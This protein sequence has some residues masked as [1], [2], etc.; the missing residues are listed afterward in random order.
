M[1]SA[2]VEIEEVNY[3][4][5]A[6]TEE[7]VRSIVLAAGS[8]AAVL[9]LRHATA[10]ERG[11]AKQPPTVDE[12]VAAVAAEPNVLRRPILLVGGRAIVGFDRAAYE[13]LS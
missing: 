7:Q 3:A 8:V 13:A 1:R 4:K 10:K 2:G 9:N 11:W 5:A 6:L 12:L